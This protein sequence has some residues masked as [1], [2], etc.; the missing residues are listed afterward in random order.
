MAASTR[1]G[2]D[3]TDD[4]LLLALAGIELAAATVHDAV[5]GTGLLDATSSALVASFAEH[6]R[7][8]ALAYTEH[9]DADDPPEADPDA[10]EALFTPV[11]GAADAASL[12]QGALAIEEAMGATAVD[13]C[14][15]LADQD[16]AGLV[17][18]VAA[19]EARHHAILGV[20]LNRPPDAEPGTSTLGGSLLDG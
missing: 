13:A 14:A 12:L 10:L 6:H 2:A 16:T 1:A 19:V 15:R 17:A 11:F 7:A 8:H 18:R 20:A 9:L 5:I 4:D 3:A